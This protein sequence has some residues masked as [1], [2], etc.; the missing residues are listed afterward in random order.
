M[1]TRIAVPASRMGN[2]AER[3][4]DDSIRRIAPQGVLASL[5]KKLLKLER[6]CSIEKGPFTVF[7]LF[8]R[9]EAPNRWDL[10]V[11]ADWLDRDDRSL[12]VYL[13]R[14]MTALLASSE[15]IMVARIA[16]MSPKDDFIQTVL[17][18][19]RIEHG[20]EQLGQG[21]FGQVSIE[22]AF[23]ITSLRRTRAKRATR[24]IR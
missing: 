6:E 4:A 8:L 15:R 18:S 11:S 16:I 7:G 1:G 12:L 2:T 13:A 24:K 14:K 20:L 19:V 10:V 22:R 17:D 23:V 5:L 3:L 9:E 21:E